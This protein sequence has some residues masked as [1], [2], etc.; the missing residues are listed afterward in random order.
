MFLMMAGFSLS[1]LVEDFHAED[2]CNAKDD[3][4]KAGIQTKALILQGEHSRS[5][6]ELSFLICI[7]VSN[8]SARVGC[9]I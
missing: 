8:N 3:L 4:I 2:D 1:S 5:R 7:S 9:F 6:F